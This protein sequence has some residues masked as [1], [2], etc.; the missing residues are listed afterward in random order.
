MTCN[1][2]LRRDEEGRE[3]KKI[4]DK[5]HTSRWLTR[6]CDGKQSEGEDAQGQGRRGMNDDRGWRQRYEGKDEDS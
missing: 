3:L 6:G 5:E 2:V 1:E 4:C